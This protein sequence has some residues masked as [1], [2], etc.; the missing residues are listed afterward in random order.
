MKAN[1]VRIELIIFQT[2]FVLFL[3][4]AEWTGLRNYVFVFF[5]L[6]QVSEWVKVLIL[7]PFVFVIQI[8]LLKAEEF[9]KIGLFTYGFVLFVEIFTLLLNAGKENLNAGSLIAKGIEGFL[10]FAI[11][12]LN[13]Q[14]ILIKNERRKNE[15]VNK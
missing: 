4:L 6:F 9:Y 11:L 13:F 10:I 5:S 7:I 12:F 2:L 14:M 1:K 8:F 15:K 3:L